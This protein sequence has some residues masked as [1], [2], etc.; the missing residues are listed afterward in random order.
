M[1]TIKAFIRTSKKSE[2]VNI[3]FRLTDGRDFQIFHT[4]NFEV[5]PNLWDANKEGIKAKV[6]TSFDKKEFND[7]I[8]DRKKLISDIYEAKGKLLNSV[9][10]NIEI[11]K[12]LYPEI[13]A[14]TEIKDETFFQFIDRFIKNAP[15][16]RHKRTGRLLN[17]HS[18]KQ[19]Q[20]TQKHLIEFAKSIRKKD[21]EF[22]DIDNTFYQNFTTYLQSKGY[23]QN[24][25][26]KHIKHIKLFINESD[27]SEADISDFHVFTEEVD[28]VYL[29]ESELKQIRDF[30]FS[31]ALHLDRVRDYFLLLA[32]TGSRY[33]DLDKIHP[34]DVKDGFISFRQQKTNDKVTI[35]I[36]PVVNE[37]LEKYNYNMPKL[38]ANQ[39]FNDLIKD[40]CRH[41]GIDRM[42]T[43]TRTMGGKLVKESM[44]KYRLIS[45]HTGRRSFCTNMYKRKLPTIMIMSISG[46]TTEKAFLKYIKVTQKEHAEMMA[47][48]WKLIYK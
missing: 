44:P 18:I 6:M 40:V 41:V 48:E 35:P 20:N 24:T 7:K 11:D 12:S 15:Y 29:D 28:N 5:M 22:S 33:S 26:G 31:N 2:S 23:A 4:S 21:F 8:I 17:P 9:L 39:N 42:E 3:R 25:V 10:L 47:N 36:H 37:I 19:Y 13:Y 43:I 1:A 27:T 38:L 32:W 46:H 30:D 16:R 45:S 14:P 34:Q